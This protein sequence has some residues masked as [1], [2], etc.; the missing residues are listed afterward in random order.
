MIKQEKLIQQTRERWEDN[1]LVFPSSVGSIKNKNNLYKDFYR[2]IELAGLPKIRFHD[3]RHTAATL[4]I[5]NG[6]PINVVSKI[7]GHSNP[8]ITLSTYTHCMTGMQEGA[9][10]MMAKHTLPIQI[11]NFPSKNPEKLPQNYTRKSEK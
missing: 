1:D 10:E 2:I 6:I 3:L 9:A 7:L 5:T 11:Q 8:S 4:M